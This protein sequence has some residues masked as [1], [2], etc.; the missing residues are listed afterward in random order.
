MKRSIALLVLT[1]VLVISGCGTVTDTPQ[2]TTA[3]PVPTETVAPTPTPTP[4]PSPT[5]RIVHTIRSIFPGEEPVGQADV[6][7]ELNKRLDEDILIR[8]KLSWS[9]SD[10]YDDSIAAAVASGDIDL[11]WCASS[12]LG[13]Y[14]KKQLI[15]AIDE[16][17]EEFGQSI[18]ENID[19]RL[20]D[21]MKIGGA[22]M[23]IPSAGNTP[24][25]DA[26]HVLTVREDLR[27]KYNLPELDSLANIEQF[28]KT[29]KEKEPEVTP[30]CTDS[31]VAAV[32]KAFG[33]EDF[34]PGT[35]NAVAFRV[36]D[37]GTVSCMNVQD[38]PSFAGAVKRIR[39][40]Y[41]SG[42]IP[43]D[44]L[45]I[46]DAKERLSSGKAAASAG[47]ALSAVPVQ[48]GMYDGEL[49]VMLM[50]VPV[51]GGVKYYT[52]N[53]GNALCV[54]SASKAADKVVQFL[55]WVYSSQENYD[56][57]NYGIDGVHYEITDG[58]FVQLDKSY[59]AFPSSIFR[60]MNY[61]RYPLGVSDEYAEAM[62]H[63][64]DGAE[65]SPLIGFSFSTSNV[66]DELAKVKAVFST[67]APLLNTGSTGSD[68][69]LAE[70][71]AKMKAAGQDKIV[72]EAQSQVEAFLAAK[73]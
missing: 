64:N 69:L 53:G 41:Q 37:D 31:A 52:G 51:S 61:H 3:K 1:L 72:A 9:P 57:I 2:P 62:K 21:T 27:T 44:M 34:L 66:K 29:I 22:L 47:K 50:D 48:A 46:E 5:P 73:Q 33:P 45:A 7:D 17:M 8:L 70:F 20:F 26:D 4:T 11:L 71:A 32:M 68:A 54:S 13:D 65:L 38:A 43:R 40:W 63:W 23:G 28:L 24:I 10:G 39:Q 58:R 18:Y 14:A 42:W 60:N 30:L 36:N 12:K 59:A 25:A 67:Y 15:S 6:F 56:F 19:A 49:D 16:P 35:N 55:N